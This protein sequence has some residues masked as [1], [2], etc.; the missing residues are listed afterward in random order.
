M[1]YLE[2]PKDFKYSVEVSGC[3]IEYNGK[4]LL[5]LRPKHKLHGGTWQFPGGKHEKGED[6]LNALKRELMEEI[7]LSFEN[8]PVFRK[9]FYVEHF[10]IKM[11]YNVYSYVYEVEPSIFITDEHENYMWVT[12]RE[13]LNMPLIIDGDMVLKYLYNL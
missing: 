4:F 12:P 10:G 9:E 7:G 13:A 8:S 3:C 6:S 5:L 1:I 2:K 11:K